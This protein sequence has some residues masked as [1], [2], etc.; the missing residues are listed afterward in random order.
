MKKSLLFILCVMA[1]VSCRQFGILDLKFQTKS[2]FN[3]DTKLIIKNNETKSLTDV[4]I[5]ICPIDSDD[6]YYYN[7]EKITAKNREIISLS[8]FKDDDGESFNAKR[9][10][11]I[12]IESDQ[13]QWKSEKEE[14]DDID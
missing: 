3:K 4:T 12:T 6:E 14:D 5:T 1:L 13:G 2:R 10:G 11:Q 7:I 9:I 8:K